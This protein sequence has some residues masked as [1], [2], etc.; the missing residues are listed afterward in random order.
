MHELALCEGALSVAL[1]AAG[2][3]KIARVKVRVGQLQR[4]LP[5]SWD[6][7]WQMVTMDTQ[8]K[9]SRSQLVDVPARVLC[10]SCGV[11]G[12]PASPLD[13][14]SCGS[15]SVLVV[16][17]DDIIVEEVELANGEIVANP[18]FATAGQAQP[19]TTEER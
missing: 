19:T 12:P 13:C 7:C 11:E 2:G 9:D 1:E 10:R 14:G 8:A 3:H 16:A 5:Q 18:D 15:H 6:M 17:G 4:V